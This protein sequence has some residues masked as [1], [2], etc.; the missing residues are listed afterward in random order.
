NGKPDDKRR[1]REDESQSDRRTQEDG[2]GELGPGDGRFGDRDGKGDGADAGRGG[3]FENRE[4]DRVAAEI[5]V[6]EGDLVLSRP[7]GRQLLVAGDE[8]A[9]WP[10]D[11]IEYAIL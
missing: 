9:G 1:C 11:T 7:P 8:R 5:L 4:P 10:V 2:L 3:A 6:G